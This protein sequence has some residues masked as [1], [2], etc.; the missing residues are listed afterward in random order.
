M[1]KYNEIKKLLK[2]EFLKRSWNHTLYVDVYDMIDKF[3]YEQ[4]YKLESVK[5]KMTQERSN[6]NKKKIK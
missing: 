6:S 3:I 2:D 1:K 5:K 4:F